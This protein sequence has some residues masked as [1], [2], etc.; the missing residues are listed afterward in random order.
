MKH[1]DLQKERH[2][3]QDVICSGNRL[4]RDCKIERKKNKQ[5]NNKAIRKINKKLC[6]KDECI[7]EY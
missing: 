5:S 1:S 3:N 4:C 6:E 2:A 7:Y